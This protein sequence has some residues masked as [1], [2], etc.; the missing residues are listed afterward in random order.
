MTSLSSIVRTPVISVEAYGCTMNSGESRLAMDMLRR[1]GYDVIRGPVD[2]DR[3]DIEG[4]IIFTC[5]VIDST[6]R[7]M[8]RRMEEI[9]SSGIPLYVA[10]CLAVIDPATVIKRFPDAKI[11]DSMGIRNL[12]ISIKDAF[13]P[14]KAGQVA[15]RPSQA[16]LRIDHIVPIATGCIGGCTYCITREARGSHISRTQDDVIKRI[17][18]GSRRGLN[19]IL[20]TSQDTGAWGVDLGDGFDL[21][22][23]LCSIFSE[24]SPDI[25]IRI[26]MMNPQHLERIGSGIIDAMEDIRLF[27]FLHLPLQSGS[28]R[29]LGMMGRKYSAGSAIESIKEIRRRY[30]DMTISTDIITGFPTETDEDHMM[31]IEMLKEIYPDILNITRYSRRKGTPADTMKGQVIGSVSKAR[32]REITRIQG[33]LTSSRLEKRLGLH[34]GCLVTEVGKEGTMMAR[35]RNYTPLVIPGGID[36]LGTFLDIRADSTGPTY[37]IGHPE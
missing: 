25:R 17:D 14:V 9:H 30:P 27:R 3:V 22:H 32:S 15:D 19:E 13:Q 11:L 37:L 8:Y 10:G 26:G 1:F 4:A 12:E 33:S 20:L 28:D 18:Q 2:P 7:R 31:S 23:L 6:E 21:P 35:D 29:I 24:S 36:L 5:D 16:P 34:K